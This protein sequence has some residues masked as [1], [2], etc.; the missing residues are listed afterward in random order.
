MKNIGKYNGI[1]CYVCSHGE[2]AN[3]Y[4]SDQDNGKQIF[5]I[6]GNMVKQNVVIGFY[7]GKHVQDKYDG[8]VYWRGKEVKQVYDVKT[9]ST[10][11]EPEPIEVPVIKEI[12]FSDYSR[13]VDD[14]FANLPD[15]TV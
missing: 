9:S 5:I 11:G 14:F 12:V 7:D 10:T 6:D 13:V 4:N 8:K 3:V 2:Y 15:P 1:P